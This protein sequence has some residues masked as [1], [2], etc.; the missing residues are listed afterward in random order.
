MRNSDR[1]Q[2]KINKEYIDAQRKIFSNYS[3][4]LSELVNYSTRHFYLSFIFIALF[5][6]I[7]NNLSSLF[8]KSDTVNYISTGIFSLILVIICFVLKSSYKDELSDLP[9]NQRKVLISNVSLRRGDT[10]APT[11]TASFVEALL[12]TEE[13]VAR[14]NSLETIYLITSEDVD[15]KKSAQ[16]LKRK[17]TSD[18]RHVEI[19]PI[20]CKNFDENV[21]RIQEQIDEYIKQIKKK[22]S[23]C[24]IIA[25]VTGGT[26]EMSIALYVVCK[27][28]NILAV[29][30]DSKKNSSTGQVFTNQIDIND[31]NHT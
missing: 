9:L 19:L 10:K 14:K 17:Y 13:K 12:Y 30:L 7:L 16:F 27:K 1:L 24:H 4:T 25:D 2:I 8:A 3:G 11:P 15:V 28:Y 31:K 6:L 20:Q 5:N 18:E 29:Y 26:K 21:L 22:Y 23:A